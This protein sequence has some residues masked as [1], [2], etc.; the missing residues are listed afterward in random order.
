[1]KRLL[2]V[3]ALAGC[4]TENT[5]HEGPIDEDGD[6]FAVEE[7]CDDADP[8]VNPEAEER[9]DG[10]D[11]N[12]DGVIDADAADRSTWY[13]DGDGD[14]YGAGDPLE[15]CEAPPG[16]VTSSDDCDDAD[17]AVNPGATELCD[18]I[19]NDCDGAIDD[20]DPDVADAQTWWVD[21]DGDG[22]GDPETETTGCTPPSDAVSDNTDCDD[23]SADNWPGNTE[24]CDAADNDCDAAVDEG[25]L[26]SGEACPAEDCAA[27]M[28]DQPAAPSDAYWLTLGEDP[29]QEYCDT[30][31]EGGGWVLLAISSDDGVATWTW[32]NRR[33]MD[34]DTTTFGDIDDLTLD[35]KSRAWHIVA[36]TDLLFIHRP[37]GMTALYEGVGDGSVDLGAFIG[38]L[39]EARCLDTTDGYPLTG[40]TL[41]GS[42]LCSTDLYFNP[43][44][45]DGPGGCDHRAA[46]QDAHGPAWSML[47]NDGCPFDD[48]GRASMGSDAY[49]PDV[50]YVGRGYGQYLGLNTGAAEAGENQLWALAR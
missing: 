20:D 36:F 45:Q 10:I 48:P 9:C 47:N 11:N 41:S 31:T 21:A 2:L 7:D 6:G 37:S 34:T 1:M 29:A 38:A 33:I 49:E 42:A 5:L 32:N 15:G 17:E 24:L 30:T 4:K 14:G 12:C 23:A 28:A 26:G 16:A 19:D 25:V 27:V 13:A 40:G 3:L 35:Y 18:G 44:D 50:E 39:D 22:Y 43:A 8:A 46:L